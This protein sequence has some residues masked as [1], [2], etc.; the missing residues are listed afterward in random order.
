[1]NEIITLFVVVVNRKFTKTHI[2]SSLKSLEMSCAMAIN[3]VG[4]IDSTRVKKS[5]F[6]CVLFQA[7]SLTNLSKLNVGAF[8]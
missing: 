8:S 5:W 4:Y 6:L 2:L 1:M 3:F 7:L